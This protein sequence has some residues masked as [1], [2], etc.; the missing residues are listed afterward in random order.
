MSKICTSAI[1]ALAIALS[2][3]SAHA[4]MF[5][6]DWAAGDPGSYGINNTGGTFESIH[7]EFD[8][9][10]ER[11]LWSVTFSD[12]VTEGFT[13]ALNS[14]PNPKGHAGELAL[15]YVDA[16]ITNDVK[17]A[18]YAYNG[19]N[20]RDSFKDGNGNAAGNQA[21]DFIQNM[22]MA[23]MINSASVTDA[24]GKR[25]IVFDIDASD[26]N[27]HIPLYPDAVDPWF[28]IGYA[29]KLGLWMHPYQGFAPTY[30][31]NGSIASLSVRS[32]GWFDGSNFDTD[33]MT[34]TPGTLALAG[35]A[36][37]AF[38]RRRRS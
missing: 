3:G 18:A 34:P 31:P 14:G 11:L 20:T 17:I 37:V 13:L 6:W 8:T 25:T 19:Q 1:G 22:G 30:N 35:L 23:G 27:A 4:T 2:A 36:G 24:A 32:Q 33:M 7:A 38:G 28:G 9:V 12:Q 5:A 16:R 21:P 26:I 29:E 15:L 10:S